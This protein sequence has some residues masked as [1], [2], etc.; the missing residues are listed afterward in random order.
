MNTTARSWFA[1]AQASARRFLTQDRRAP[2]M[3]RPLDRELVDRALAKDQA[4]LDRLLELVVPALYLRV[5]FVLRRRAAAARGR[6]VRQELDD[7]VQDV[8][9]RLFADRGKILRDWDP[10]RGL[11]IERF[12][13]LVAERHIASQLRS[14][15]RNPWTEDPTLAELLNE[16]EDLAPSAEVRFAN[17]EMC[18]LILD[19]LRARLSPL[20]LHLFYALIVDGRDVGTVAAETKLPKR[21]MYNWK[22]RLLRT[23]H[24]I[25]GEI[26]KETGGEP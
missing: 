1:L 16:Q 11:T 14:H 4:S 18:E 2:L 3:S 10:E 22:H 25:A 7:M 12:V 5:A 19:R 6:D 13:G 24:E 23:V 8:L 21:A 15:R 17:R 26:E 20:A 9:L